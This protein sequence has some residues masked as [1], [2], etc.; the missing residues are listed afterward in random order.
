MAHELAAVQ[1][2]GESSGTACLRRW[3]FSLFQPL[4][5]RFQ[6]QRCHENA[7]EFR[8]RHDRARHAHENRI[9]G[10]CAFESQR[11]AGLGARDRDLRRFIAG[12]VFVASEPFPIRVT[13]SDDARVERGSSEHDRVRVGDHPVVK[14][15]ISIGF[16]ELVSVRLERR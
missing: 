11:Q 5:E 14:R 9:V 3:S 4:V 12:N 7:D 2:N 1:K 13:G 16:V 8:I 10:G 15:T 6:M